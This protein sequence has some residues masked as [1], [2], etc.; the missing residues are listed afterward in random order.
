MWA[1]F[2]SLDFFIW[3]MLQI[4]KYLSVPWRVIYA[5]IICILYVS[6]KVVKE[7]NT[8]ICKMLAP[9]QM[10]RDWLLRIPGQNLAFNLL[11]ATYSTISCPAVCYLFYVNC[12][13]LC[14]I[15]STMRAEVLFYLLL[16]PPIVQRAL[17]NLGSVA[18]TDFCWMSDVKTHVAALLYDACGVEDVRGGWQMSQ[19]SQAGPFWI[20]ELLPL[21]PVS[22]GFWNSGSPLPSKGL[23]RPLQERQFRRQQP[24]DAATCYR[25][26]RGPQYDYSECVSH[27]DSFRTQ[28]HRRCTSRWERGKGAGGNPST[29]MASSPL[30]AK[31]SP[32][33][34]AGMNP[35]RT[36]SAKRGKLAFGRLAVSAN[37]SPT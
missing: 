26:Q 3:K 25:K 11:P 23:Q 27:C 31:L 35:S 24:D 8:I 20:P 19:G 29:N 13:F 7:L 10:P 32:F 30:L 4:K 17:Y 28:V 15:E 18:D 22:N 21:L 1:N 36:G 37:W 5:R 12:I 33:T 9:E 16:I 34:S 14:S 6:W 2:V